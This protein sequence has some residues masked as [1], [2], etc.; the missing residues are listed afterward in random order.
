MLSDE[1]WSY[2]S[3]DNGML[4]IYFAED[5][6]CGRISTGNNYGCS[7]EIIVCAP[8]ITDCN[9]GASDCEILDLQVSISGPTYMPTS[10][11]TW[12]YNGDT[13]NIVVYRWWYKKVNGNGEP[14]VI[15]YGKNGVFSA[16]AD[17]FAS[18]GVNSY[19]EIYL[20]VIDDCGFH[21]FSPTYT[22]LKKGKFKIV[23]PM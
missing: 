22:I 23:S 7:K 11:M 9:P 15:A 21:Y 19:F 13:S 6:T 18:V 1:S 17:T 14:F 3:L 2:Q 16:T 4:R 20:E 5:F 10:T 12:T 8:G